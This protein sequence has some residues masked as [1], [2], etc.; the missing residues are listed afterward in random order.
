MDVDVR[1]DREACRPRINLAF[2][3]ERGVDGRGGYIVR[4]CGGRVPSK[5]PSVRFLYM[6]VILAA[7][8]CV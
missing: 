6:P 1:L 8:S 3:S 2:G 5:C 7:N 4:A